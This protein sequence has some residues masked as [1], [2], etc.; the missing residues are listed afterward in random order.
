MP[1]GFTMLSK[2]HFPH[3]MVVNLERIER[4]Q[5]SA[6]SGGRSHKAAR[7]QG[8]YGWYNDNHPRQ[9]KLDLILD[10]LSHY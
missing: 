7:K 1:T 3:L 8:P 2:Q 6:I 9:G 4:T 5:H 10:V